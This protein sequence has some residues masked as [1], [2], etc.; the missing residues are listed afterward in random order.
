MTFNPYDNKILDAQI[1][2]IDDKIL[3]EENS[4]EETDLTHFN[5]EKAKHFK[6]N[7]FKSQVIAEFKKVIKSQ[8]F[9]LRMDYIFEILPIGI[10]DK[11]LDLVKENIDLCKKF[12][13]EGGNREKRN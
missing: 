11:D 13:K 12:S 5:L 10:F 3:K 1:K 8:S 6:E 2:E 7:K 4:L 9:N